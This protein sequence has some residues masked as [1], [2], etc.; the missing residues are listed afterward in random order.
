VYTITCCT[1]IICKPLCRAVE[2]NRATHT[3]AIETVLYCQ[4]HFATNC[5]ALKAA[6]QTPAAL[7]CSICVHA[8]TCS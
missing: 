3:R 5:L 8:R 1:R 4:I 2:V 7:L 6:S